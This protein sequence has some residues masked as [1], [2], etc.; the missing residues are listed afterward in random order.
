MFWFTI[1]N[2]IFKEEKL[3]SDQE[4]SGGFNDF[5]SLE[6]AIDALEYGTSMYEKDF[7]KNLKKVQDFL[8]KKKKIKMQIIKMI[9]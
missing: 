5:D 1:I 3:S 9:K 4:K 8:K 6:D 2:K 7:N